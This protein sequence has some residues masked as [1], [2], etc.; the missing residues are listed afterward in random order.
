MPRR[1]RFG[2][3]C[4]CTEIIIVAHRWVR[5]RT[6]IYFSAVVEFIEIC[7]SGECDVKRIIV[8]GNVNCRALL[9]G[10]TEQPAI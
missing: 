4:D 10:R 5:D 9:S 8:S 7:Q 1:Q 2:D 6:V 3:E